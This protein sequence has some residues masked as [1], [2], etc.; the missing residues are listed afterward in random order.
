M[1]RTLANFIDGRLQPA[2]GGRWLDV[3]EPATGAV[4]AQCPDSDARDVEAAVAAATRAAPGWA[5]TPV[6]QRASRFDRGSDRDEG[7]P[8]AYPVRELLPSRIADAVGP[9]PLLVVACRI[10][11]ADDRIPARPFGQH[12]GV[13]QRGEIPAEVR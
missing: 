9:A 5:T 2:I 3:H 7:S 13:V 12:D 11:S 8:I 4:F 6:E 1:M 10:Q